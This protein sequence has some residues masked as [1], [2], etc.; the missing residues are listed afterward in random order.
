IEI[1][2]VLADAVESVDA[3]AGYEVR[4]FSFSLLFADQDDFTGEVGRL[5]GY[6]ALIIL[7]ILAFV[8]WLSPQGNAGVLGSVRRTAADTLLTLFTIFAAISFMQGLGYLL[9]EAG[10]IGS[11]NPVTQIIPV[12]LIGLG[13]D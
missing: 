12:L 3:P 13:V 11:F 8:F 10:L 9:I 6:A 4:A 1:E 2:T 5:F 7:V